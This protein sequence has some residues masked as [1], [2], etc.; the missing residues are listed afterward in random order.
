MDYPEFECTSDHKLKQISST[1]YVANLSFPKSKIYIYF[2]E[3]NLFET[4]LS[5]L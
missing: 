2:C 1:S 5:E 4:N 3:K